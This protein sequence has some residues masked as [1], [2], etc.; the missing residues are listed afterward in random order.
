MVT[1][2]ANAYDTTE[3]SADGTIPLIYNENVVEELYDKDILMPLGDDVT[4][5]LSGSGNQM[6][7]YAEETHYGVNELT[8]GEEISIS[9]LDFSN[10]TMSIKWYGDAKEWSEQSEVSVFPFVLNRMRANA[11]GAIGENRTDVILTE[12]YNT[13]SSA[14]YP[15][16]TDGSHYS[17]ADVDKNAILQY[18]QIVAAGITMNVNKLK[19]KYVVAHP[20]QK[21]GLIQDS[22]ITNNESY[23]K[24][25]MERGE[26]KTI[27]GVQIVF[28]NSIQTATENSKTVYIALGLSE[29]P[30]YVGKKVAPRYAIGERNFL[31]LGK[32]FRYHEAFG[33]KVKRDEGIIPLKSVGTI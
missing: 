7:F 23:N 12:L 19:M 32:A 15:Y 14:I 3:A 20:Y 21:F 10:D 29:K 27:D 26:L 30:F 25:V 28:H 4:N 31:I 22:R 2:D 24:N 6:Q 33:V 11:A 18:E 9:A 8:E 16:K 5:L 17:S 1:L 13:S